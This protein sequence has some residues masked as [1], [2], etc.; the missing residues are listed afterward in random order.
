[1]DGFL[2]GP[3][4]GQG[5]F[6]VPA[7]RDQRISVK[8]SRRRE[9]RDDDETTEKDAERPEPKHGIPILPRKECDCFLFALD[10]LPRRE[11]CS[12][13]PFE[14][15]LAESQN[16]NRSILI[17]PMQPPKHSPV[18]IPIGNQWLNVSLSD[19]MQP[20]NRIPFASM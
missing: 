3:N 17:R 13:I 14:E 2:G 7:L 19:A 4:S 11:S 8:D 16:I 20:P 1:V 15:K 18:L 6:F 9:D 12:A 5:G 10:Q